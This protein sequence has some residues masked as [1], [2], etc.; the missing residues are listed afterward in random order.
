MEAKNS[1]YQ[2]G[3]INSTKIIF[4]SFSFYLTSKPNSKFKGI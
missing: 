4:L 2:K 1:K 3:M